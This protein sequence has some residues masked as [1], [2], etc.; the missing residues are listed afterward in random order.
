MK[1]DLRGLDGF[2][3]SA[4]LSDAPE[5]PTPEWPRRMDLDRIEFDPEQ[6]RRT[7]SQDYLQE[8]AESI[9]AHG[10]L[11]PVSLRENPTKPGWYIVNRGECRCRASRLAGESSVP[12]FIDNK[13]DRFAQAV[14]NLQREDLTPFDLALFIAKREKEGFK[15]A[16]IARR[17][18]KPAS[19][20]TEAAGLIGAAPEVQ[21]VFQAGRARDTRVLYTLA[22]ALKDKPE[23][24]RPLLEQSGAITREAIEAILNPPLRPSPSVPDNSQAQRPAE[25]TR[26]APLDVEL[27]AD[28]VKAA[29]PKR[30]G[31]ALLVEHD[32]RRARLGWTK[33]PD[34][35][36]GEVMYEDD[37]STKVV[38]LSELKILEWTAR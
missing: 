2:K 16:E 9:K 15:R 37:G 13:V 36:I 22:R 1:L 12:Y 20:I 31:N 21:E 30:L 24:V 5:V 18:Q 28:N 17:L 6:P 26:T 3:A 4:L 8:L 25:P 10:V 33:Q 23:A 34:R 38:R 14:E 11:E 32:G 35:K 29:A 27:T 19:F 7:I